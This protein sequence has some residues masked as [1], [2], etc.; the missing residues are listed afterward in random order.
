MRT[1]TLQSIYIKAK[2]RPPGYVED[3]L[4][5]GTIKGDSV[6]LSNEAY[7]ELAG[8]YRAHG[9]TAVSQ[10]HGEWPTYK[11]RAGAG[12]ELK[13]L[14]KKI[15][16]TSSENCSCNRRAAIMDEKGVEWVEQ[17]VPL[18]VGWLREEAAKRKLPFVDIAGT[19]LVKVAIRNAKRKAR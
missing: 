3:V 8:K 1:F 13:L 17:N 14:L 16:I 7:K 5:R 19:A 2:Q 9:G 10:A 6:I 11:P 12:T 4:S 18:V 15:G